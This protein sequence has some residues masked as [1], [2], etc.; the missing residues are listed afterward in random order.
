MK[1]RELKELRFHPSLEIYLRRAISK[2]AHNFLENCKNDFNQDEYNHNPLEKYVMLRRAFFIQNLVE[3]VQSIEFLIQGVNPSLNVA[4]ITGTMIKWLIFSFLPKNADR[5]GNRQNKGKD[6]IVSNTW[7]EKNWFLTI[8]VKRKKGK[9]ER[10]REHAMF[11]RYQKYSGTSTMFESNVTELRSKNSRPIR[12]EIS[13]FERGDF[14]VSASFFRMRSSD[15]IPTREYSGKRK[16]GGSFAWTYQRRYKSE[17]AM[18][19][20]KTEVRLW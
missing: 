17:S 5:R 6:Y 19:E 20:K 4:Q 14:P 15:D 7:L 12:C 11:Q 3:A 8:Y 10:E 9:R 13:A 1:H 18:T 16:K 2:Y